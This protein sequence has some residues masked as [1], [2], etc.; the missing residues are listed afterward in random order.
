[1]TWMQRNYDTNTASYI[2]VATTN[3]FSYT[4]VNG[5]RTAWRRHSDWCG[6]KASVA[7]AQ[8]LTLCPAPRPIRW[9]RH[10][11]FS[12]IHRRTNP[13]NAASVFKFKASRTARLVSPSIFNRPGGEI[14]LV[15]TTDLAPA[16]GPPCITSTILATAVWMPHRFHDRDQQATV[17]SDRRQFA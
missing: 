15:S 6:H 12:G 2:Y 7:P 4:A 13:T 17:L 8:R 16:H 1:M 10:E 9:R 14:T 5:I 3:V 11:Q